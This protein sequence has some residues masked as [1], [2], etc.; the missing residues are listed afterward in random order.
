MTKKYRVKIDTPWAPKGTF[1][2]ESYLVDG[3][4]VVA[5]E[6]EEKLGSYFRTN[7]ENFP[8]IFERVQTPV[9]KMEKW[10]KQQFYEHPVSSAETVAQKLLDAGLDPERLK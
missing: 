10:I 6:I 4:W 2:R 8:E 3:R 9:E 1:Y 7:P 5:R